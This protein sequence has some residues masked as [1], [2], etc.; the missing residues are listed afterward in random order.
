MDREKITCFVTKEQDF[1]LYIFTIYQL[2]NQLPYGKKNDIN[3]CNLIKLNKYFNLK[4]VDNDYTSKYKTNKKIE[5]NKRSLIW[6]IQGRKFPMF[7]F[8]KKFSPSLNEKAGKSQPL[9]LGLVTRE[10]QP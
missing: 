8:Y 4:K 9:I 3:K 5:S 6:V 1:I 10:S 7:F 2:P